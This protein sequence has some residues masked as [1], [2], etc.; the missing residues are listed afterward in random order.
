MIK[1]RQIIRSK[2]KSTVS[3]ISVVVRAPTMIPKLDDSNDLLI[4]L[5]SGVTIQLC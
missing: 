1:E 3:G 5:P 2:A 4:T